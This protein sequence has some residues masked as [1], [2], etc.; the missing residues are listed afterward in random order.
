MKEIIKIDIKIIE[1][2]LFNIKK[3]IKNCKGRIK[4][5]TN[6][7]EP[8]GIVDPIITNL[9]NLEKEKQNKNI[10]LDM[11]KALLIML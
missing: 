7:Q 2:D 9:M 3:E 5:Y 4:H 1:K 8:K 11:L 6:L 10:T